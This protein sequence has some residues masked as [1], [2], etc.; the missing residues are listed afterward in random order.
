M[1]LKPKFGFDELLF[2]MQP[3]D[4]EK[5]WGKPDFTFKDEEKNTI[6]IYNE[7]SCRLTFYQEEG[8]K[9]SLILCSNPNLKFNNQ[10][11]INQPENSVDAIFK[12]IKNWDKEEEDISTI[13]FNEDNWLYLQL[14]FKKITKVEMGVVNKNLDEFDWK[15]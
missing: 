8:N 10:S 15:F 14:E 6:F 13:Y 1:E 5:V 7:K 4:V 9:L 2:G 3:K 12:D 11:L